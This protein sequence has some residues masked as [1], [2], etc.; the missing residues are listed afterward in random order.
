MRPA[1]STWKAAEAAL[2]EFA[3]S[4][5][6]TREEFPWGDRVVKVKGKVFVFLGRS[7]GDE[8]GLSVKL[9][10][11]GMVALDLPFASPTG[12]GLGKSGWVT[13]RFSAHD[14]VPVPLLREWIA[15]SYRAVAPAKLVAALDGAAAPPR[16]ARPK[17]TKPPVKA[18]AARSGKKARGEATRA[19]SARA[20]KKR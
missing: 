14:H 2:R 11:S 19:T 4:F 17:G 15:E 10:S 13:A 7:D 18:G 12:Y 8:F 5:P 3:L 16:P 9:P 6:E 20:A 1:P